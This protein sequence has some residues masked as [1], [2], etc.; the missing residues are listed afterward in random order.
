MNFT[1]LLG[2]L[3]S[4]QATMLAEILQEFIAIEKLLAQHSNKPGQGKFLM[5]ARICSASLKSPPWNI[6]I[7]TLSEIC[8]NTTQWSQDIDEWSE[9]SKL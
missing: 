4:Y 8:D 3:T 6:G 5:E 7:A 9:R 2:E 1:D